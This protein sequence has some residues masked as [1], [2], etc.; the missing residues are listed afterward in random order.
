[1]ENQG[2]AWLTA[3]EHERREKE[4]LEELFLYERSKNS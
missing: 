4:V 2:R 1:M 3:T